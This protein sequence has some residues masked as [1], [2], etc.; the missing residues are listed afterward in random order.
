MVILESLGVQCKLTVTAALY[1]QCVNYLQRSGTQHLIF[2]IS[3][4]NSRGYNYGV[5][6]M[7]ANR[8]KVLHGTYSYNVAL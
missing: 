6:C 4:S 3:K 5:T 2:L 7:Y 1:F 8:V